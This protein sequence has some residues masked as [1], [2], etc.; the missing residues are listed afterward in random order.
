MKHIANSNTIHIDPEEFPMHHPRA[1]DH[2]NSKL[3]EAF[4][5]DL[6]FEYD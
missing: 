1:I 4:K 6:L 5:G 2:V 3:D